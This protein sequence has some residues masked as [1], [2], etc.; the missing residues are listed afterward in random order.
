MFVILL[1]STSVNDWSRYYKELQILETFVVMTLVI[2]ECYIL[3]LNKYKRNEMQNVQKGS[4][5]IIVT[6]EIQ[7]NPEIL[8]KMFTTRQLEKNKKIIVE[9]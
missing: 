5:T 4:K 9:R 3:T 7:M 8:N 1:Y 2:K 6:K